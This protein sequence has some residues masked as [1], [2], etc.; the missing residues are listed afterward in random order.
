MTTEKDRLAALNFYEILDTPQ[1]GAFDTIV[2]LAKDFLDVPI[3]LI[4]LVDEDRIWFKSG[5]GLP[6]KQLNR[7]PGFCSS[8]IISDEFYEIQDAIKDIR[9]SNHSLVRQKNGLRFYAAQPLTT[10]DGFNLGTLCVMDRK[11]R[12]LNNEQKEQ[13]KM[14]AIVV[15]QQLETRLKSRLAV[16]AQHNLSNMVTHDLKNSIGNIPLLM[17]ILMEQAESPDK[18]RNIAKLTQNAANKS[19]A[20]IQEYMIEAKKLSIPEVFKK[21]VIDLTKLL[22][23]VIQIN[24]VSANRKK[25][26]IQTSLP[27]KLILKG[28]AKKLAE[29]A[30][31]LI[32]N[33]IKYSPMGKSIYVELSK[34][35]LNC[36]LIVRD[37]G[38]GMTKDDLKK[39]F[40]RFNKLSAKPT[41][42]EDSTG[43]GL[44]IVKEIAEKHNGS[45]RVVS[46]GKNKGTTF[47]IKIALK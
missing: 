45:V 38:L 2:K 30:D 9:S 37:N 28:D 4:S 40:I 35:L 24:E 31:N 29:L 16:Q 8:A 33:A 20:V 17:D 47:E 13:L 34:D 19:F 7:E 44:W 12:M 27:D 10:E 11:P 39:A 46:E 18:V 43:L 41:G 26:I 22:K 21:E 36:T 42:D 6:V 15:M 3:A 23:S 32:N 1:D 5:V 25:Q 14:L